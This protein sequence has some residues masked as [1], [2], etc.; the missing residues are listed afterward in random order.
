MLL[1]RSGE[2]VDAWC[3]ARGLA[4]GGMLSVEQTWRLATIW[5][6]DRADPAW[7]RKT[8]DEAEA[9]FADLGLTG[10]FWRLR[11]A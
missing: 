9:I 6:G 4:R 7:R 3:R 11:V 8:L 1:F 10:P 2:H 5:Y